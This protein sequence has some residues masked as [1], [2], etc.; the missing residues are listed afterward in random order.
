MLK[1]MLDKEPLA[2]LE[3]AKVVAVYVA[4][5][6]LA[7]AEAAVGTLPF[8][9]KFAVVSLVVAGLVKVQRDKVWSPSSVRA[10]AEKI[11]GGS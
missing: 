2:A 6:L 9:V 4:V 3:A 8:E 1:D 10:L 7:V 11:A 5:R